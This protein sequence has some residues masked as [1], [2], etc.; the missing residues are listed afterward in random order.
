MGAAKRQRSDGL[1][2][3]GPTKR[4]RAAPIG[5]SGRIMPP[6][7]LIPELDDDVQCAYYAIELLRV[8]WRASHASG[9]FLNGKRNPCSQ[10]GPFTFL[11]GRPNVGGS[12]V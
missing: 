2:N 1:E 4:V 5:P 8:S 11:S 6:P 9:I 10:L 7:A 12:V 3:P